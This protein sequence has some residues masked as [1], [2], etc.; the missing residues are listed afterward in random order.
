MRLTSSPRWAARNLLY[1]LADAPE[2]A[3]NC[4]T[5]GGFVCVN[6]PRRF[7]QSVI[8]LQMLPQ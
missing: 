8:T 7:P 3:R 2:P 5:C 1:A 4:H 6:A